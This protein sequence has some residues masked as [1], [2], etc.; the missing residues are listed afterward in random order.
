[1]PDFAELR[2][3]MVDTQLR[4]CNVSGS[5]LLRAFLTIAREL[6]VT[7]ADQAVAYCDDCLEL[8]QGRFMLPPSLL[9]Q[10]IQALDPKVNENILTIGC[11]TGYAATILG[12]LSKQVT[13]LEDND[14]MARAAEQNLS[15]CNSCNVQV[16]VGPVTKGWAADAPYDAI[17]IEGAVPEVP[18]ALFKQLTEQGR[19]VVILQHSENKLG[20]AYLFQRQGEGISKRQLFKAACPTLQEFSATPEFRFN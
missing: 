20:T 19:I 14:S 6:F 3:T 2:R 7:E 15:Q 10:L 1:M 8:G 16:V 12:Y 17:L 5:L 18:A 4:P 13:A 9:G 11:G